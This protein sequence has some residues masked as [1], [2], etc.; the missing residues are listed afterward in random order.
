MLYSIVGLVERYLSHNGAGYR[1]DTP[2]PFNGTPAFVS[3]AVHRGS[4]PTPKDDIESMVRTS[5]KHTLISHI[6]TLT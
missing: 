6:H 1:E 2:K 3:L 4:Q 5:H